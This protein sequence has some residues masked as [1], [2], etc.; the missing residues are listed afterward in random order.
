MPS[1]IAPISATRRTL[2]RALA[3]AGALGLTGAGLA[4]SAPATTA[5]QRDFTTLSA[6]MTGFP[7]PAAE[8][9][10]R[11]YK[12]FAT[13]ARRTKLA[14]LAQLVAATPA[15]DLDAALN[16]NG[17]TA[18]ANELTSA[19]FSGIVNGPKGQQ[20]VLYTDAYVW[21]AMTFSKPMGQCGGA[22]GYWSA[23]PA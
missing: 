6:A 3:G 12:A 7:A 17:L 1:S 15:A 23:P 5:S 10:T 14:A 18:L 4:A 20:V 11:M 2:L 9:A 16:T 13:P 19:W 21:T 22:F 8:V